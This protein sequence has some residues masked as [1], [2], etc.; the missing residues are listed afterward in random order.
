MKLKFVSKFSNS[1]QEEILV[2]PVDEP[3]G[4]K[5]KSKT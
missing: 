3:V 5:T 4:N 1:L 2:V